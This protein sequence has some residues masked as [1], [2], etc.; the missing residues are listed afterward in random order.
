[1]EH[2]PDNLVR[3]SGIYTTKQR[4]CHHNESRF[5]LLLEYHVGRQ[6]QHEGTV[7]KYVSKAT[8]QIKPNSTMWTAQLGSQE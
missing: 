6:E 8:I 4:Y 3:C 7:L 5:L 2:S 1:M